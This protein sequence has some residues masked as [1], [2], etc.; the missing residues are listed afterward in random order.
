MSLHI[1]FISSHSIP[2]VLIN[3]TAVKL[4][5]MISAL[6]MSPAFAAGSIEGV[7]DLDGAGNQSI[8]YGVSGDGT[9]VVGQSISTFGFEAFIWTNAGGI[10]GLGNLDG[11][12]DSEA[13]ASNTNGSVITGNSNSASGPEAFIWTSTDGMIGI[14]DLTGGTY[15]SY[16]KAINADGT[17]VVGVSNGSN[18]NE[19][20]RWTNATGM[21]GLGELAGGSF[22]SQSTG[23]NS[24]GTVVVGYSDSTLGLQ[25]FRWTQA[26]GMVGIGDLAGG[27]FGSQARAVNS[28]GT[29]IIGTGNSTNGT[30]AFRWTQADGMIG[31]GDLAGGTFNS[32]GLA[33]NAD[34]T[35]VVGTSNATSGNTGFRWTADDGMIS[36][37]QWLTDAGVDTSDF[38]TISNASSVSNDGN[39]VVGTGTSDGYTQAYIAKVASSS[40]SGG[41][42]ENGLVGLT[43]LAN[44]MAQSLAI[45]SQIESL[46][47]LSMNG[48]HHRTLADSTTG[49][50]QHCAWVNG[51][52]SQHWRQANG[53]SG[54]GEIGFCHD[55][56]ESNL[57]MGLGVGH[58]T[59]NLRL[60]NNGSS[61]IAGQYALAEIDWFIPNSQIV[62]SVLGSYGQWDAELARGYAIAGTIRSKGETDLTA[63]SL[64]TRLDWVDIWQLKSVSFSPRLAYTVFKSKADAY[65]EEGG[66]APANF[67]KQTHTGKELRIGITG[68]YIY[69]PKVTLRGHAEATHRFDE[70][71]AK[72][73]GNINAL[74]VDIAFSQPGSEIKQNWVRMGAELDYSLNQMNVINVSSFVASDGQ[75]ADMT[76][77]VSWKL[78]F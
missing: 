10:S 23:V 16:A 38:A 58:S 32:E 9:T 2:K 40:G 18:G 8:A 28:D 69:N 72:V 62:A 27:S 44:S 75:D 14:G 24:D 39:T 66:S 45:S 11:A 36:I 52:L 3:K 12:F 50:G 19:A 73:S 51:D 30:E 1:P 35:V 76:A 70:T 20:Y 42:N 78:A 67:Q 53:T 5:M 17:V 65:Q 49:Q 59:T 15:A 47:L 7:G 48:A 25:A 71:G 55:F 54:L 64:R 4:S 29:V 57:K 26:T 33:V 74:G 61:H 41:N 56:N 22:D 34:G 37:E 46:L 63:Y 6:V 31:L 21:I 60:A 13:I 43:D 68:K 77:A